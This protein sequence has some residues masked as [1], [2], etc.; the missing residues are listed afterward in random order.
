MCH[1]G[2]RKQRCHRGCRKRDLISCLWILLPHVGLRG[3]GLWYYVRDYY[4]H[5]KVK[6][7]TFLGRIAQ[8]GERQLDTLE[9][10]GSSPVAPITFQETQ[11][12]IAIGAH[13]T[14]A[15]AV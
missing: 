15:A 13:E 9:V 7:F 5:R 10:T 1:K 11:A 4:L 8:L 3:K 12:T 6:S 2:L 14:I